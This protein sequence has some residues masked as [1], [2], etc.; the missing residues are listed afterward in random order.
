ME[1]E[2]ERTEITRKRKGG[3]RSYRSI[4]K[5]KGI[6]VERSMETRIVIKQRPVM[7]GREARR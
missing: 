3:R 4:G 1:D 2:K 5:V 7:A 6:E